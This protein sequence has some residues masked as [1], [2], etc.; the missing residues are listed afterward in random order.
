MRVVREARVRVPITC[1]TVILPVLSESR[2]EE[3]GDEA[4]ALP[5]T[6]AAARHARIFRV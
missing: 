1:M 4:D 3:R 2:P 6:R 5:K